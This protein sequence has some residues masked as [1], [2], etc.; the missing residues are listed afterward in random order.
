M[1]KYAHLL[2][3]FCIRGILRTRSQQAKGW[4]ANDRSYETANGAMK[5][6]TAYVAALYWKGEQ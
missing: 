5:P 4:G 6:V 2:R 3:Q 1:V